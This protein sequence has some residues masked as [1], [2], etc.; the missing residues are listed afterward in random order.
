MVILSLP[1][2]SENFIS[3]TN[4]KKKKKLLVIFFGGG[5]K[6]G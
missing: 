5:G 6:E 1:A 4:K 3:I 2:F